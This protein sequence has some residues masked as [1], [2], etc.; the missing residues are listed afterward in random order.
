[1]GS[2]RGVNAFAFV[3]SLGRRGRGV[4]EGGGRR[5]RET[6]R[7]GKESVTGRKARTD[8]G[9]GPGMTWRKAREEETEK[10]EK[11]DS[12][13]EERERERRGAFRRSFRW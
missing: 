12:R 9:R 11:R 3:L 6:G 5:R 1:M 4:T 8:E 7:K 10:R 13:R 2:Q